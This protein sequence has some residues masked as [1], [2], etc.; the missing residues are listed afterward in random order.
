[1]AHH[2]YIQLWFLQL[3]GIIIHF[4]WIMS[5]ATHPKSPQFYIFPLLTAVTKTT[6]DVSV[7]WVG[8]KRE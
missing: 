3:H 8:D 2:L 5:N 7:L 1:M 6:A 4:N